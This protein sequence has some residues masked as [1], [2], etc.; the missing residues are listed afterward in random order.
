MRVRVSRLVAF[1]WRDGQ[2]ICDDPLRHR[3]FALTGEAERRLRPYAQWT[4]L[5]E[6]DML[7]RRLLDAHV[8]VAEGSPGHALEE[9]LGA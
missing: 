3:Q 4:E 7:A 9:R 2:L 5:A 8:L 6:D 1:W